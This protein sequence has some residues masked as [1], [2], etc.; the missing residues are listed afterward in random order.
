MSP[1]EDF[2][3]LVVGSILENVSLECHNTMTVKR[4]QVMEVFWEDFMLVE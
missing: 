3:K 1:G 2:L 4:G